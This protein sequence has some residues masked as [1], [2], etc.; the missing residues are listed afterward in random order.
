MWRCNAHNT[1]GS[2]WDGG[3]NL[4]QGFTQQRF[5]VSTD[6]TPGSKWGAGG[7]IKQGPKSHR[8]RY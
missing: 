1:P 3:E 7:K 2:K 6:L 8:L 5:I 4:I